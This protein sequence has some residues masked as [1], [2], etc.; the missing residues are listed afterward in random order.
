MT[1]P[2]QLMCACG[3]AEVDHRRISSGCRRCLCDILPFEIRQGSVRDDGAGKTASLRE[4][5]QRFGWSR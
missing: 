3:H 4:H 2:D 1:S 5:L